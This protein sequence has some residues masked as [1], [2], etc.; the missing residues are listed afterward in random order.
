MQYPNLIIINEILQ[1]YQLNRVEESAQTYKG[2][3]TNIIHTVTGNKKSVPAIIQTCNNISAECAN[4]ANASDNNNTSPLKSAE[5]WV[6]VLIS[7]GE[8]AFSIQQDA[9]SYSRFCETLHALRTYILEF[10]DSYPELKHCLRKKCDTL[11]LA[12]KDINA[13]IDLKNKPVTDA[14]QI[15]Q[16]DKEKIELLEK[17]ATTKRSL[18]FIGK[19][20]ILSGLKKEEIQLLF[21]NLEYAPPAPTISLSSQSKTPG[22]PFQQ[23]LPMVIHTCYYKHYLTKY[24]VQKEN[25]TH[26]QIEE[27][28]I[29]RFCHRYHLNFAT[30][31]KEYTYNHEEKSVNESTSRASSENDSRNQAIALDSTDSEESETAL[32]DST[33]AISTSLGMSPAS[34]APDVSAITEVIPPAATPV[35]A[36]NSPVSVESKA[37]NDAAT[38]QS[39]LKKNGKSRKSKR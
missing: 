17:Q 14:E 5:L 8:R 27:F 22:L 33:S 24:F 30:I 37:A 26:Q 31:A 2:M 36:L 34:A 9:Y 11:E 28:I 12:L 19:M 13:Q 35:S 21:P 32:S 10:V 25:K 6:E 16:N 23:N 38:E 39:E 1:E 29:R 7:L 4:A 15:K 18:V 20:D 3:F